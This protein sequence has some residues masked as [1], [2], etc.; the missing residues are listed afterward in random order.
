[1][2]PKGADQIIT[3]AIDAHVQAEQAKRGGDEDGRPV[4]WSQL[5]N[6][7]EGS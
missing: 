5:A 6:G 1:M 7:L 2:R 3:S 4:C